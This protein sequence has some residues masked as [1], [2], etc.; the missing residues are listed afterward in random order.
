MHALT[1]VLNTFS[2]LLQ[3]AHFL[4]SFDCGQTTH[5]FSLIDEEN[6]LT[7]VC[8]GFHSVEAALW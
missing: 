8:I 6:Y 7:L 5:I 1:Q 2:E 3:L 4:A